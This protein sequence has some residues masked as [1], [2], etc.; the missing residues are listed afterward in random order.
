MQ[1]KSKKKKND[2]FS[3]VPDKSIL[4]K[5]LTAARKQEM[6]HCLP[7]LTT[8]LAYC[9]EEAW[10]NSPKTFERSLFKVGEI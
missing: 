9:G 5:E 4:W 6:S 10:V 2:I 7:G 3:G 8:K 1:K